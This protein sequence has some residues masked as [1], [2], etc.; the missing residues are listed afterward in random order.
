MSSGGKDT[1][2]TENTSRNK[3][4]A[5]EWLSTMEAPLASSLHTQVFVSVAK[6]IEDFE[7]PK[8]SGEK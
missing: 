6:V 8:I 1:N 5:L 3:E 4:K 2:K 7:N